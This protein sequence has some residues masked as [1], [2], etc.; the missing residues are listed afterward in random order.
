MLESNMSRDQA[1]ESKAA[2]QL[3]AL[4]DGELDPGTAAQACASWRDAAASRDVWHTY[5]L[6][7]D[8]MRSDD[9]ASTAVRDAT[10]LARLRTRLA[11]EPV[12]LAPEPLAAAA[13]LAAPARG[14]VGVARRWRA[15]AAVAAGFV[16]V[17]G[18]LIV[19]RAPQQVAPQMAAAAPPLAASGV[20]PGVGAAEPGPEPQT[21]VPTR[22]FIRDCRLDRY[23]AAH[24]QF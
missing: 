6:I 22:G 1:Q 19:T 17:A 21:L 10:F 14:K 18:V 20:S 23:L 5:H 24:Q 13:V 8:V 15:P 2:E 12:V 16:A 3:S 9:L 4:L 7:G 11:D